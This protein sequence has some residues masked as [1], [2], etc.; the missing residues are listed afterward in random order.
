METKVMKEVHVGPTPKGGVRSEAYYS[1]ADGNA[2]D[3]SVAT[4]MEIVE[5]DAAGEVL[6]RTYG[7]CD[8]KKSA[9]QA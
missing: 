9:S 8:P 2:A 7:I 5:F 3:K 6:G 4:R 1:D